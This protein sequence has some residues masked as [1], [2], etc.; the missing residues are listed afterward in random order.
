MSDRALTLRDLNRATLARQHLAARTADPVA[1]VVGHLVGLQAQTSMAPFVGL[2]TRVEG[3][4]RD[5]VAAPVESREL[6]KATL[7]RGTLHLARATD[8]PVLRSTLQPVLTAALEDVAK[9][10]GGVPDVPALVAA[11]RELLGTRPRSFTEI[12][13]LLTELVPDG[14]PGVMRYA[15]RTHLPLVQVPTS[16]HW[17]FP[18]NPTWA[19]AEEWLGAP[20]DAEPD[21]GTLVRRYLAAFGPATAKDVS[22]WCY[23]GGLEA[24]V[25]SMRDELVVYRDE[26][27]RELFDVPGAPLP[28][29]G[30]DVPPRFLPE[31]D[32]LLLSHADRRRFVPEEHRRQVYLPGLRVAATLLVDGFVAGTWKVE[33]QGKKLATLRLV[34]FS[35]LPRAVRAAVADEAER[36]VRFAAPDAR[37]V[38]VE[39]AT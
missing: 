6:V 21:D 19:L 32:N 24:V 33:R 9:G 3:L 12:T 16:A 34:P 39:I 23:L 10:R 2:W 7:M 4:T 36:L 18:G 1:T 22:T 13:A 17:S 30:V 14:D 37:G 28:D 29:G 38:A 15:V 25:T 8:Y 27:G 26:T 5:G 35:P 31:F 11:A 20:V